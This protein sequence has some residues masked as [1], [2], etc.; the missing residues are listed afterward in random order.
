MQEEKGNDLA[1][2][3]ATLRRLLELEPQRREALARLDRLCVV[4]EKWVELAGVLAREVAAADSAGDRAAAAAFRQRL[5]EL[6]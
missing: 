1:G 6:R 2:A 3:I 4:T 5:G